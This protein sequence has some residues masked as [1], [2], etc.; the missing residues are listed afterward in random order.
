MQEN[1]P[2]SNSVIQSVS[3]PVIEPVVQTAV[4][5]PANDQSPKANSFLVVL[6]SILLFISVSIAG[7]FAYQ[8]QKLVKEL[9]TLKTV[10]IPEVTIE[11]VATTDPTADWKTY[12]NNKYSL[13][14]KYPDSWEIVP[15][16]ASSDPE[17]QVKFTK[18][19]SD[20]ISILFSDN[21]G[22]IK[23]AKYSLANGAPFQ[24]KNI[25]N[26]EVKYFRNDVGYQYIFDF[27]GR[28]MEIVSI[29]DNTNEIS[30]IL[31]TFTN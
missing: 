5:V 24:T 30:Q 19:G 2:E 28:S 16:P 15:P 12:T 26:I 1:L 13:V 17:D 20:I 31:S 23:I 4:A 27:N 25:E 8:T 6:L 29:G 3:N 21:D 11:P 14:F 10:P 9:T 7:F 22:S 18:N